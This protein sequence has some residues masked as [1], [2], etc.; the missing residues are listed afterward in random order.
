[1]SSIWVL[2]FCLLTHPEMIIENIEEFN[3]QYDK[4]LSLLRAEWAGSRDM[5][6]LRQA[7]R[8]L[9]GLCQQLH[10][11]HALLGLDALPD[12]SAYDQIWLGIHW[13]PHLRQL[14]LQQA[15]VVLASKQVYNQQAIET[16]L[17][18]SN[19]S[20]DFDIQFFT[21]SLAAMHWLT[22]ESPRLPALLAEWAAAYGP[23]LPPLSG[24]AE[25]RAA[26]H[27]S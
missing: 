9:E 22:D 6:R 3:I 5:S 2:P 14:P 27:R 11:T 7:F 26:Y 21:Q 24:V 17:L 18:T 4:P 12:I 20:F 23:T 13:L 1:M 8:Q 16:I 19:M 10:V 15:V 25:A